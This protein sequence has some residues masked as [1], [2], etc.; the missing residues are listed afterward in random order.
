MLRTG[1]FDKEKYFVKHERIKHAILN[2][3][4]H[5]K[6]LQRLPLGN[7]AAGPKN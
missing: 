3:M 7:Y 4:Q 5:F 1:Y 2:N 6:L